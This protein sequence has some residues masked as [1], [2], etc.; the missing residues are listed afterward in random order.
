MKIMK[1][2]FLPASS[3][4]R[5]SYG[6]MVMWWRRVVFFCIWKEY[7]TCLRWK[8]Q[9]CCLTTCVMDFMDLM[10]SYWRSKQPKQ[11]KW[12]FW[13]ILFAMS[14]FAQHLQGSTGLICGPVLQG[15]ITNLWHEFLWIYLDSFVP[16]ELLECKTIGE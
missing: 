9:H 16:S 15:I 5:S 12:N 8:K 6:R 1:D 11:T 10:Q 2:F 7:S 4:T 3:V 13:R 14:F